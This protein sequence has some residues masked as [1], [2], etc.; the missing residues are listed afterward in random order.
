MGMA[1]ILVMW[2]R[3]FEQTPRKLYVKFDFDWPIGFWAEDVWRLWT[4]TDNGGLPS[5]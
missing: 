4:T 2:P 3:S 5:L 1:A